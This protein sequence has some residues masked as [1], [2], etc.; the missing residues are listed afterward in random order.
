V[1]DEEHDA[2]GDQPRDRAARD[3]DFELALEYG[4]DGHPARLADRDPAIRHRHGLRAGVPAH[5]GDDR[6]VDGQDRPRADRSLEQPDD[7]RACRR[8]R[9]VHE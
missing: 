5:P 2:A 6:H 1:V 9:Q 3:T 4:P 7:R 8:Q